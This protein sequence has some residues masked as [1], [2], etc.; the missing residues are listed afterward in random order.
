MLALFSTTATSIQ[1]TMWRGRK[2]TSEK[3]S[4]RNWTANSGCHTEGAGN[5]Q[6]I[7]VVQTEEADENL[8][9]VF[10]SSKDCDPNTTLA[11]GDGTDEDNLCVQ[12]SYSS[13]EI[14]ST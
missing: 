1:L 13:F 5:S 9:A 3:F 2:C 8:Y 4:H 10:F 14:W 7:T 11:W 12:A 6:G